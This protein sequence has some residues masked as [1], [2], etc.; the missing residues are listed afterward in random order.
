[1]HFFIKR[2]VKAGALYFALVV[3]AG[4]VFGP[5]RIPWIEAVANC[6]HLK[7]LRF[8]PNLPYA[9]TEHG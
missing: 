7:R 9:F 3:G 8:S 5:I 4:F 2:V 1:M 6:D